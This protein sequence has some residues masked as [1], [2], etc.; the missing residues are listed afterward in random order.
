MASLR[1][2]AI[3]DAYRLTGADNIAA[4]LRCCARN[5]TRPLAVPGMIT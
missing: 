1:N 4:A 3:S 5:A 2:F